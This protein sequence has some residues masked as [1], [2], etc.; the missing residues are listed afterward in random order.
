MSEVLSEENREILDPPDIEVKREEKEE[1]KRYVAEV[2]QEF[3]GP[4][5]PPS[6]IRG[7]E[8]I[9]PGTADRIISMAE[10]Q[11]AHRQEMEKQMVRAES[12]DGLLGVLFAFVIV[13]TCLVAAV[14][15]VWLVPSSASAIAGS[16]LGI[17]GVGS[18]IATFIKGTRSN[19][20]SGE[21]ETQETKTD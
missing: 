19:H 17:T 21:N 11:A 3:S 16:L 6:I 5:P 20:S 7:Y 10:R 9:L 18:V 13:M 15:I 12:R 2:I 14:F 1:V 4:I 8:E